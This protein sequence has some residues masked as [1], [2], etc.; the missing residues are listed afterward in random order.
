MGER[1]WAAFAWLFSTSCGGNT[2]NN[3]EEE[4]GPFLF[5][6]SII[7][8]KGPFGRT[9]PPPQWGESGTRCNSRNG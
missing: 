7:P 3:G 1:D 9:P 4:E 8:L 2:K 5:L 6:P